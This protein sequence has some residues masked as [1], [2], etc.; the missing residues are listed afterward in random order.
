MILPASGLDVW[1]VKGRIATMCGRSFSSRT[2]GVGGSVIP[3]IEHANIPA[4]MR[5]AAV[6]AAKMLLKDSPGFFGVPPRR[7]IS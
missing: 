6:A 5:S 4:A 3:W 1:F 7:G 2:S